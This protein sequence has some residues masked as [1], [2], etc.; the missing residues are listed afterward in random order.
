MRFD[1]GGPDRAIFETRTFDV[2]VIGS[3]PAGMTLARTLAARGLDVALMEGGDLEWTP[4]SQDVYVGE[5]VGLEYFDLDAARLRQ[6]GG[7][8]GHWNG[9]CREL[10]PE[11]FEARPYHAL[12]AWPIGKADL[13]PYQP[14]AD[15]I[16]DV[17][18]P[19]Q[20]DIP[21][22][23]EDF[24]RVQ[25]RFSPPTRFAREIRRRDRRGAADLLCLNASLVDLRLDDDLAS[26]TAAVFKSYAPGDPGFTVRARGYALCCGGIDNARL[27]LNFTSQAPAGIGNGHGLVGRYF[28]EHPRLLHRRGDLRGAA[29]RR[30]AVLHADRGVHGRERDAEPGAALQP[31]GRR[32]RRPARPGAGAQPAVRRAV[33]RR[34]WPRRSTAAPWPA[35]AAGSPTTWRCAVPRARCGRGW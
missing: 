2:C 32:R 24:R 4:E 30:V 17:S 22:P 12:G 18:A 7:T 19:A 33:R 29:R 11:N 14:E 35:T 31:P 5:N 15:A 23:G 10:D 9:L 27:L 1:A 34:G 3:G 26:V 21:I 6:F 13:D 16:L 25:F 8:S 28:T 20:P